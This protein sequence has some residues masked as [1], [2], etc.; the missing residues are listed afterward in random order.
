MKTLITAIMFAFG[1]IAPALAANGGIAKGNSFLLVLFLGFF[2]L[3]AVF[4]FIPG[5]VLF[6]SMLK[7]LFTAAPKKGSVTVEKR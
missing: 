5:L 6:F 4:Q 1:W 7:G 2:A 3:I